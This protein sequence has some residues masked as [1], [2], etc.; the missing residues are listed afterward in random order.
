M[1]IIN[2]TD[3][4]R[5]Y[6]NLD[7]NAKE[8]IDEIN[9]SKQWFPYTNGYNP[10]GTECESAVKGESLSINIDSS[11]SKVYSSILKVFVE[12]INDYLL[13]NND[14]IDIGNLDINPIDADGNKRPAH[15]LIR[16]YFPGTT[17]SEHHDAILSMN[18]GG[19]T[20]LLY[21]NDDYEGGELMFNKENISV[22]P[23][24]GSLIIFPE[25]TSHE[26]LLV[27]EGN[28]YMT[29]GY[30]FRKYPEYLPHAINT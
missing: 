3:K 10:D 13:S 30:I 29:T 11:F 27:K 20:A 14:Q 22:K 16:K 19:Y 18:E 1:E 28:R 15:I 7:L 6:K 5:Y 26:V 12:C 4:I 17:M 24:S 21:F 2:L 8:V 25:K 23:N 9:K